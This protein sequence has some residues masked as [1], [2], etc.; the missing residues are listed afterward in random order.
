MVDGRAEIFA[1]AP[2]LLAYQIPA[3]VA[4]LR[5]GFGLRPAAYGPDNRAPS[6]GA[7]FVVSWQ[8]ADGREQVLFRR[9]LQPRQNPADRDIHSLDVVLPPGPG[10]LRLRIDAGPAGNPASDWTFWSDLVLVTFR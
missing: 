6:D 1:H 8:A 7:E 2:S 5:G 4:A 3:G 10:E 9:L